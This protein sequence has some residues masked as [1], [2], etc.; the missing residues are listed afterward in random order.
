MFLNMLTLTFYASFV[1]YNFNKNDFYCQSLVQLY[2]ECVLL[3]SD[4]VFHIVF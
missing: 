3:V 4:T 1:K 2:L